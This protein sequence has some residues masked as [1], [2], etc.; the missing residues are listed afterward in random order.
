MFAGF[1]GA[2]LGK[3]WGGADHFSALDWLRYTGF[4]YTLHFTAAWILNGYCG[5]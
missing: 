4:H 5:R 2:G 1:S 3:H